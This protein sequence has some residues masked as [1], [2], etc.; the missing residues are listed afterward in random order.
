MDVGPTPLPAGGLD[1]LGVGPPRSQQETLT[2]RAVEVAVVMHRDGALAFPVAYAVGGPAAGTWPIGSLPQPRIIW[3]VI[4]P[5]QLLTP[6]RS[7]PEKVPIWPTVWPRT[8]CGSATASFMAHAYSLASSLLRPM[9][10]PS[11]PPP[12]PCER[13]FPPPWEPFPQPGSSQRLPPPCAE[14]RPPFSA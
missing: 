12:P 3:Y 7:L 9:P 1:V 10:L 5:R 14:H 4:P 2:S 6:S 11:G 8:R 13:H